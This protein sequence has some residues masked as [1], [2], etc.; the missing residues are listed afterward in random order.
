MCVCGAWERPRPRSC[1][2][3]SLSESLTHGP[4]TAWPCDKV[5]TPSRG[6][7]WTQ[8]QPDRS[9]V[10]PSVT[11]A[12]ED[13]G[14]LGQLTPLPVVHSGLEPLGCLSSWP[15]LESVQNAQAS[16][17]HLMSPPHPQTLRLESPSPRSLSRSSGCNCHPSLL[18]LPSVYRAW[19][20]K[21]IPPWEVLLGFCFLL[22]SE[23]EAS[24]V[25]SRDQSDRKEPVLTAQALGPH[26]AGP[27]PHFTT[28][29]ILSSR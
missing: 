24:L 8:G 18:V 6:R 5:H 28:G 22:H 26:S 15:V 14:R 10:K 20:P 12:G 21:L 29:G 1:L 17:K 2:P 27:N 9:R 3:S 4:P 13:R 23:S 11:P 16:L 7:L 25:S 19:N